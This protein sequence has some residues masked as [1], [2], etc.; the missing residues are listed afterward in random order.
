MAKI[1]SL[2]DLVQ[3]LQTVKRLL[4]KS[5]LS[6]PNQNCL[7]S[8]SKDDGSILTNIAESLGK[9]SPTSNKA[10]NTLLFYHIILKLIENYTYLCNFDSTNSMDFISIRSA[11]FRKMPDC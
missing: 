1:S 2:C 6:E 5:L 8:I 10:L 11:Y 4:K 7:F 9:K 3:C